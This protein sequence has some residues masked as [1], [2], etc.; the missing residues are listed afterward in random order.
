[1]QI[2]AITN[3]I[4]TT[5]QYNTNKSN[6]SISTPNFTGFLRFLPKKN[7]L[8]YVKLD[9]DITIFSPKELK[10]NYKKMLQ[11]KLKK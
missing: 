1:M 10:K 11:E 2:T 5:K 3:T 6:N 9:S 8:R 7:S 4:N